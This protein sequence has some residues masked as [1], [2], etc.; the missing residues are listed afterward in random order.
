MGDGELVGAGTEEVSF[1]GTSQE[2]QGSTKASTPPAA[3]TGR[4]QV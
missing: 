3:S 1:T 2:A 4:Q